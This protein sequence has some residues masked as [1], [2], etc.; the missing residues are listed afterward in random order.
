MNCSHCGASV[1]GTM[2]Y[3][4]KCGT[5]V[6]TVADQSPQAAKP[7][8]TPKK[9]G[10]SVGC[11]VALVVVGALAIPMLGIVAAALFPAI[12]N[13]RLQANAAAV[14]ARGRE[15]CVGIISANMDQESLGKGAIWP[16]TPLPGG[17]S[18]D[19]TDAFSKGF[20]TSTEYFKA[21]M[22]EAHYGTDTWKPSMPG[23]DY[24]TLS[25]AGV[26]P[27]KDRNL[28]AANNLWS[29]AANLTEE[30]HD[31]VPLLI[32][33][34]VDVN[35]I[36]RAVNQGLKERDF[37]TR[38]DLGSGKERLNFGRQMI[39]VVR[40]DGSV[41]RLRTRQTTLGTLFDHQTLPP[42]DPSKPKIVYLMP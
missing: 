8:A 39:V 36:E 2:Q 31:Q 23:F 30:D 28:T 16:K 18:N 21:L 27:C 34:N 42:R 19:K 4:L 9:K 7:P 11:I 41:V 29:I 14:A 10:L 38:I 22:D 37:N 12:S 25:G 26:P 15:I 13:A 3:C 20:T 1:D 5:P 33:C 40:K 6:N 17:A 32:T 35:A 24:A